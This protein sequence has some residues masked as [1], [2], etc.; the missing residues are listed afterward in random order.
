MGTLSAEAA[1]TL[2]P[3]SEGDTS[4]FSLVSDVVF[5]LDAI[6]T[7]FSFPRHISAHDFFSL[8][9]ISI[10]VKVNAEIGFKGFAFGLISTS[11]RALSCGE[12]CCWCC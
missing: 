10:E 8:F 6:P 11:K 3:D 12:F 2:E 4:L 9:F 1:V 5:D 7:F